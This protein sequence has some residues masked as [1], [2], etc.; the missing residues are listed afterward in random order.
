M[1]ITILS[2][3]PRSYSTRRLREAAREAGLEV[4]VKD[5]LQFAIA[6]EQQ[7]PFLMYR[8]RRFTP[9]DAVI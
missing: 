2:R 7:S 4:E 1:R 9:G 5:T 6:L 8:G 3:S